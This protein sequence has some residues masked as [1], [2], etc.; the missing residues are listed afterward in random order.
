MLA[1]R[2]SLSN[3]AFC[4]LFAPSTTMELYDWWLLLV[5][6]N[7]QCQRIYPMWHNYQCHRINSMI[8]L[9]MSTDWQCHLITSGNEA[10]VSMSYHCHQI[11]S[12]IQLPVS[13]NYPC[14]W[15]TIVTQWPVSSSCQMS[16]IDLYYCHPITNVN[17]LP[18]SSSYSVSNESPA[19]TNLPNVK[20]LP[21]SSNYRCQWLTNSTFTIVI[22]L[23]L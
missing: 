16:S 8:Q 17:R 22:Q 15:V 18:V 2:D 14:Q 4:D 10:P 20:Q 12:V 21:L 23:P 13:S 3:L 1:I 7:G 11:A 9:P 5:S 19:S 6:S